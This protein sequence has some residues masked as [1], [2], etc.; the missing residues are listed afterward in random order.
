MRELILQ[1]EGAKDI[2][3]SKK[4]TELEPLKGGKASILSQL[5]WKMVA[6]VGGWSALKI[7]D[8]STTT[9]TRRLQITFKI[10]DWRLFEH[11]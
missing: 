2:I 10:N 6:G 5:S 8:I 9:K 1:R 3:S 4:K 11:V 7:P